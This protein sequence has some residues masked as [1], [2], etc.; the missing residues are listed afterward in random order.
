MPRRAPMGI[1]WIPF[2][3]TGSRDPDPSV[4]IQCVNGMEPMANELL[5][6]GLNCIFRDVHPTA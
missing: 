3:G 5:S 2:D 6:H 4:F 1:I